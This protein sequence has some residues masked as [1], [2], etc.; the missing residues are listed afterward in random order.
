MPRPRRR[1]DPEQQRCQFHRCRRRD[2]T[3]LKRL[4]STPPSTNL[5]LAVFLFTAAYSAFHSLSW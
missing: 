4:K 2:T 3:V 1:G 5:P